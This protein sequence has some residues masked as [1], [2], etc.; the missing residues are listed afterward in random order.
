M[1][2]RFTLVFDL[3]I[4]DLM[5]Q[6]LVPVEEPSMVGRQIISGNPWQ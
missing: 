1:C 2:G 4:I 5:Q 6:C 3:S